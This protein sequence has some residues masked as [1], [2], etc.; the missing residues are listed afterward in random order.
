MIISEKI[1]K[2]Y[3]KK[4]NYEKG[5]VNIAFFCYFIVYMFKSF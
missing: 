4:R 2:C 3:G 1:K 5:K